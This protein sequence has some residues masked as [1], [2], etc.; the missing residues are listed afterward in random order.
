MN[1]N[2]PSSNSSSSYDGRV[3]PSQGDLE[4]L[5]FNKDDFFSAELHD[6]F[7]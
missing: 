4:D 3:S 1:N 7:P 6:H 5:E 2:A